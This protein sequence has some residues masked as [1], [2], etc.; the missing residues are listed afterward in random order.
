MAQTV[1]VTGGTGFIAGWCIVELL[2]RGYA[3]RTTVR[4]LSKEPAARAAGESGRFPGPRLQGIQD[5]AGCTAGVFRSPATGSSEFT[6]ILPGAVFGPTLAADNLSSV[7]IIQGLLEG[8]PAAVPRLGFWV[9][10]VRDLADLHI[11]A[12]TSAEAAGQR[13]I[14]AGDFMW[15]EDI[16]KTLG[17]GLGARASKFPSHRLPPF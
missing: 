6:P 2:R 1:L 3:V 7:Q 8:R 13:F 17:A 14:A 16:A 12:V 4:S 11:R 5:T 9:V 10:D 15:L